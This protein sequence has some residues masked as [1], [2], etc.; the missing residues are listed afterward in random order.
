MRWASPYQLSLFGVYNRPSGE[1]VKY[2]SNIQSMSWNQAAALAVSGRT[3]QKKDI[4]SV[5]IYLTFQ[6]VPIGQILKTTKIGW[7]T[8][9]FAFNSSTNHCS[10]IYDQGSQVALL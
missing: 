8:L 7:F 10:S 3:P 4:Y 9:T 6:Y 5:F 1:L 2:L